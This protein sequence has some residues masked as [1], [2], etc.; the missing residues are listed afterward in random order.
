MIVTMMP[1][2][3]TA[4]N[5]IRSVATDAITKTIIRHAGDNPSLGDGGEWSRSLTTA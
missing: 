5:T 4:R 2:D 3:A 1:R